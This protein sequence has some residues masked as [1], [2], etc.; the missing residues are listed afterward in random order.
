MYVQ[1]DKNIMFKLLFVL[2]VF[3][4]SIYLFIK[5]ERLDQCKTFITQYKIT[6]YLTHGANTYM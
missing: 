3:K 1:L 6:T 2:F 5:E 4:C